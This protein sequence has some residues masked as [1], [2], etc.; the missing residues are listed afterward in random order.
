YWFS[1]LRRQLREYVSAERVVYAREG[2]AV[3]G[4]RRRDVGGSDERR[5]LVEEIVAANPHGQ[6]VRDL[7]RRRQVEVA[8]RGDVRVRVRDRAVRNRAAVGRGK[9]RI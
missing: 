9:I 4:G 7:D 1:E 3:A 6:L 5:R 2:V 8:V